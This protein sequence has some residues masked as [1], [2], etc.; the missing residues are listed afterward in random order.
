MIIYILSLRGVWCLIQSVMCWI[1]VST[2]SWYWTY[3]PVIF[4]KLL[5]WHISGY[6][7]SL[8]LDLV[9]IIRKHVRLVHLRPH[10]LLK[11][12]NFIRFQYLILCLLLQLL[13]L[14]V[15]RERLRP[16]IKILLPLLLL[17]L[18]KMES[19]LH[20]QV[21]L[22]SLPVLLSADA[23]RAERRVYRVFRLRQNGQGDR[24]RLKWPTSVVRAWLLEQRGV[25]QVAGLV[26]FHWLCIV[27]R[28][29]EVIQP[30]FI[31]NACIDYTVVVNILNSLVVN[32]ISSTLW[33]FF[34][35][36]QIRL[37]KILSYHL[38]LLLQLFNWICFWGYAHDFYIL[39]WSLRNALWSHL[40]TS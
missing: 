29:Y 24:Q 28:R 27:V 30:T 7:V 22:L 36:F 11:S 39:Q 16:L 1:H 6:R 32:F 31:R 10:T 19:R 25:M 13:L 8:S 34:N 23:I 26:A 33:F 12:F 18:Q 17:L 20:P 21:L 5:L 9:M 2:L 35:N 38:L 4:R 15:R 3:W 14:N 37:F 40:Q